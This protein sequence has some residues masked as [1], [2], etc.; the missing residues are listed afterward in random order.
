MER[1]SPKTKNA[2]ELRKSHWMEYMKREED[3]YT[4]EGPTVLKRVCTIITKYNSDINTNTCV[5]LFSFYTTRNY[6]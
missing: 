6:K 4:S 3:S 1:K 2:E 5:F